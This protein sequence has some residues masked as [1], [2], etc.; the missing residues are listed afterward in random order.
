MSNNEIVNLY[1]KIHINAVISFT[2]ITAFFYMA[3]YN[4]KFFTFRLISGKPIAYIHSP[5]APPNLNYY[6]I[7]LKNSNLEEK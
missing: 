5:R 6:A 4:V 1:I 7:S 3:V 2:G